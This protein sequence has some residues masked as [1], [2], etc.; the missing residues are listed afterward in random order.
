MPP[1]RRLTVTKPSR[2]VAAALAS[3]GVPVIVA[4]GGDHAERCFL[5]FF[6]ATVRN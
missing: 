4:D 1:T 6:V 2:S 3:V 5:E